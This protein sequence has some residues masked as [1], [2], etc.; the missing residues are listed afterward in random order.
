MGGGRRPI[1]RLRAALQRWQL[2]CGVPDAAQRLGGAFG[3]YLCEHS[4]PI[5]GELPPPN[6]LTSNTDMYKSQTLKGLTLMC[7]KDLR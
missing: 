7:D 4:G 5:G 3:V 6:N 1:L 2:S